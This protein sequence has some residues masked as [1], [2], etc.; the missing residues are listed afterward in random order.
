MARFIA[1]IKLFTDGG[2]RG[3]PGP[4]A[5]GVLIL[6]SDNNELKSYAECIGET[7]NNRA[8]YMALIKGLDLCAK[9]TRKRVVCY[10]DS[11]LLIKQMTGEWRLKND[12]L[13][14]LYHE[15]HKMEDVFEKVVYQHVYRTNT[16]I[17]KVDSS[18]NKAMDGN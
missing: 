2:C 7:T 12:K 13:R 6:D 8:E 10:S 18:L 5:I 14:E 16:Y 9:F 4:G 11:Q 1:D 15:A 3:N 17:K